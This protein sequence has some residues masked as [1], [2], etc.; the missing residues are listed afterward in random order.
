MLNKTNVD[1]QQVDPE[2]SFRMK[3]HRESSSLEDQIDTSDELMEIDINEKFIADCE[4]EAARQRQRD[5]NETTDGQNNADR[6]HDAS[7]QNQTMDMIQ[8]SEASKARMYTTPGNA[9]LINSELNIE[10]NQ[11]SPLTQHYSSMV[12]ENYLVI[13]SHLDGSIQN[14]IFNSEYI[15]FS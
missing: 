8:E 10:T 4:T 14:K 13:G 1:I 2:V 3:K 9:P 6:H 12:D 15:D 7:K 11:V 5:H